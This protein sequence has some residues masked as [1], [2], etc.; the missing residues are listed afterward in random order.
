MRVPH[1]KQ[2]KAIWVLTEAL[3]PTRIH[4]HNN[5]KN[6]D[7]I[8]YFVLE[9]WLKLLLQTGPQVCLCLDWVEGL[10]EGETSLPP[11]PGVEQDRYGSVRSA[12]SGYG[13]KPM[14]RR[15]HLN[16]VGGG[17]IFTHTFQPSACIQV[18]C[19]TTKREQSAEWGE[20]RQQL[21]L[22]CIVI[23][24]SQVLETGPVAE[25]VLILVGGKRKHGLRMK[26]NKNVSM[27]C[28]YVK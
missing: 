25:L 27:F 12:V 21:G 8:K 2:H 11:S 18:V 9:Q 19:D 13:D 26:H 28:F 24:A 15:P 10:G 1:R 7:S 14:V 5:K 20:T 4:H 17:E 23:K 16:S 22:C 6:L 3:E